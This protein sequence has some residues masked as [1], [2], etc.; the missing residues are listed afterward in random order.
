MPSISTRTTSPA[1][2]KRG[3]FIAMPTPEQVPVASTSP[4]SSVITVERCSI[5]CHTSWI[6]SAVDACCRSS[7]LTNVRSISAC[8]SGTSSAVTSQGPIGPCVSHDLP[9][10]KVGLFCCQSRTDTSST[11]V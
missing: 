6:R 10:V 11:M 4:G 3:G 7:P 5:C 8:G 9:S 1:A 2:R